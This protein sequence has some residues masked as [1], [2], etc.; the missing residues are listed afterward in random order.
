MAIAIT[1]PSRS[2]PTV[3]RWTVTTSG[4]ASRRTI[5][6]ITSSIAAPASTAAAHVTSSSRSLRSRATPRVIASSPHVD[7]IAPATSPTMTP[8]ITPSAP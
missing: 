8:R 4:I 6:T 7:W 3:W 5:S 1:T 2:A